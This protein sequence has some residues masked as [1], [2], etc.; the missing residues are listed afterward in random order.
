MGYNNYH[1]PRNNSWAMGFKVQR[2]KGWDA[3]KSRL[4]WP[5]KGLKGVVRGSSKWESSDSSYG[6]QAFVQA[7]EVGPTNKQ[8]VDPYTVL[9][10][11]PESMRINGLKGIEESNVIKYGLEGLGSGGVQS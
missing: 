11:E 8:L 9:V 2:T 5:S 4:G 3:H 7:Q 1:G 6:P 10:E